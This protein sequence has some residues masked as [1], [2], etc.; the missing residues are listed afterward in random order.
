VKRLAKE[1]PGHLI[2]ASD[3]PHTGEA[4]HRKGQ[5]IEILEP[6][7]D[8]DDVAIL[9]SLRSWVS[10]EVWEKMMVGTPE[11]IFE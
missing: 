8:I 9:Q 6:F 11:K 3:W 1:V 4:K 2:W 7:R 5:S 10:A